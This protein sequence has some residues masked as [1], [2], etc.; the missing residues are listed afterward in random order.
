VERFTIDVAENDGS[1]VLTM[2]G[3]LD[4]AAAEVVRRAIVE[5]LVD[6]RSVRVDC[7]GVTFIDSIGVKALFHLLTWS[8]ERGGAVEFSFSP[9]VARVLSTLGIADRFP[10]SVAAA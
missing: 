5:R 1:Y 6:P 8:R 7:L 4:I 2:T 9:P 10:R 3:E